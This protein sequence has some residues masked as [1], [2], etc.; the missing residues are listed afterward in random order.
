MGWYATIWMIYHGLCDASKHVVYTHPSTD[1]NWACII[2]SL[3]I[4]HIVWQWEGTVACVDG[5]YV[6]ALLVIV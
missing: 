5:L 4:I 1:Y 6:Y 3:L 2:H